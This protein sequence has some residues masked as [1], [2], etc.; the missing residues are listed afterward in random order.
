ME[1]KDYLAVART[2]WRGVTVFVLFGVAVAAG[3]SMVQP[4]IYQA[5]ASGF[6]SSGTSTSPGEASVSDSLAKSRA[7]SYV[8]L[9]TSR[10]TA[11][12]V[13]DRLGL[14]ANP[15][16]LIGSVTVSQPLDTVLIKI[17]A[18]ASTPLAAQQLAD[19]WVQA[20][21][22]QVDQ[23]ENPTGVSS[24]ALHIVPIES[25]MLPG[26][27][28][29]PNT[30]RNVAL[31]FVVGLLLGFGYAVV[32]SQLDRKVRRAEDVERQ[33][34][35]TVAATIPASPAMVRRKG[36]RVPLV[37]LQG[38][39]KIHDPVH[40]SEAFLKLR[41]NLQF[42][43]ID[44]PP[45]V[46]VVTSPLPGDGKSTIAANLAAALSMSDRR[47]V[48]ID[49]DLRRPVVA[50]SFGLVEGA[51]LTDVLI[52][53]VDFADVAQSVAAL[54]NLLVLA[55]GGTPPNPSE[56]LGSKAMR[57]L[58]DSLAD[59]GYTVIIDAPPLLPVTDAAVLTASADG[60]LVAV[61]A[62]RTLDTQ[63]AAALGTLNA[64]Q[65][66]T[67]GVVLNRVS[68]KSADSGYY[69]GGYYAV[70]DTPAPAAHPAPRRRVVTFEGEDSRTAARAAG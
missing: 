28:V 44:N 62:G 18:R 45:R 25:A 49:G 10:A 3:L 31:G 11:Q 5:D 12:T 51:G 43:D 36:G 69:G 29:S 27:P 14:Q 24:Q 40:A 21:K 55:A 4:K 8:D 64:V 2:Y 20:L 60:A 63:L 35:V 46:I 70:H 66:H 17:S 30:K 58:L 42:M 13:I 37:V 34:G 50:E 68:P 22:A 61:S 39:G 26:A 54:P 52:G 33:F 38:K 48:L 32:R 23:V 41:T 57:R 7:A 16:A 65:G 15:A 56:M 53:R 9:A 67:L 6:V 19:A 1:L 47:V 59:R